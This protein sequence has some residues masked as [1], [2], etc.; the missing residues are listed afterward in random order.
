MIKKIEEIK[1]LGIFD[2]YQWKCSKDFSR[3]NICFGFNGSGKSTISNLFN[4]IA[5]WIFRTILTPQ[6]SE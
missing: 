2:S 3:H 6:I 4:L 1:K 5:S